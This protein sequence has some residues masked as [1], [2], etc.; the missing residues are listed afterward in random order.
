MKWGVIAADSVKAKQGQRG[1]GG[2]IS[3]ATVEALD[4]VVQTYRYMPSGG[5]HN[6]IRNSCAMMRHHRWEGVDDVDGVLD[7]FGFPVQRGPYIRAVYVHTSPYVFMIKLPWYRPKSVQRLSRLLLHRRLK[8]CVVMTNAN[9]VR[10]DFLKHGIDATT[11]YP[12]CNIKVEGPVLPPDER[13]NKVISVGALVVSKGHDM[14]AEIAQSLNTPC[15]IY[16]YGWPTHYGHGA[17]TRPNVPY[18]EID[19]ASRHAKVIMS[20]CHVEDFGLAVVEGMIRGAIPVVPDLYGFRETVPFPDLRYKPHDYLSAKQVLAKALAGSY[21]YL[22]DNIIDH[23]KQYDKAR[24]QR[25]LRA[26][27]G[28]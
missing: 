2:F 7:L 22:Q 1:G 6:R 24:F 3:L 27:L 15:H 26:C 4:C 9:W 16:G 18:S 17:T 11:V 23:A 20:G 5:I 28:A 12:P 19:S 25:D 21:D 8:D 13:L 14:V 10:D